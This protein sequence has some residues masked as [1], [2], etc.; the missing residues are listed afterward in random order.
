MAELSVR[1]AHGTPLQVLAALD[2]DDFLRFGALEEFSDS[3]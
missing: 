1:D 2:S 3:A